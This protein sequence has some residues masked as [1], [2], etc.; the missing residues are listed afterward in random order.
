MALA[1][2]LS[3]QNDRATFGLK[4]SASMV[5]RNDETMSFGG[6]WESFDSITMTYTYRFFDPSGNWLIRVVLTSSL[7]AP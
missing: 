4:G 5:I 1:C 6:F 2:T 3:A 7:S